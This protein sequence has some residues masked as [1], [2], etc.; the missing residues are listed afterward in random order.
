[1]E[2]KAAGDLLTASARGRV[3]I[4]KKKIVKDKRLWTG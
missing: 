1:M 2:I 4:V 3:G